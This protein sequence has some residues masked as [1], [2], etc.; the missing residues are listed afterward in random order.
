M[1]MFYMSYRK[2][3]FDTYLYAN[4]LFELLARVISVVKLPLYCEC[5]DSL[6]RRLISLAE[7]DR[8]G[9]TTASTL[10]Y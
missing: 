5:R 2:L 3:P 1:E 7:F 6:I 9:V 8:S 4:Q 10:R